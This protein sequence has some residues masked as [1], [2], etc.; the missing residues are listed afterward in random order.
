M[1]AG[2]TIAAANDADQL[3]ETHDNS[4]GDGDPIVDQIVSELLH[5]V[6]VGGGE[7]VRAGLIGRLPLVALSESNACLRRLAAAQVT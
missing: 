3:A 1:T 4:N 7:R 6:D 2:C 5:G